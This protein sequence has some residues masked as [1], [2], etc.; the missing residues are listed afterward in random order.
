MKDKIKNSRIKFT[1]L[2]IE[3]I[4][5]C[6][7]AWIKV[8]NEKYKGSNVKPV[9]DIVDFIKLKTP[10]VKE[11]YFLNLNYSQL[12]YIDNIVAENLLQVKS[13][14]KPDAVSICENIEYII[15]NNYKLPRT[16][17]LYPVSEWKYK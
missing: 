17:I 3:T 4:L 1:A 8:D 9:Q 14:T 15:K 13:V 10:K 5:H 12:L 11:H 7:N 6:L 2:D 16:D